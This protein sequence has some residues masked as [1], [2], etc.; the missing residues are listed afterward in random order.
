MLKLSLSAGETSWTMTAAEAAT[1]LGG[2]ES[3]AGAATTRRTEAKKAS[4]RESFIL[5]M[6]LAN[7]ERSVSRNALR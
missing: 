4:G 2:A 1:S 7:Q 3:G 6:L 5:R